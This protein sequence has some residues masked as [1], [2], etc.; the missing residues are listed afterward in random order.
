MA[1]PDLTER[2]RRYWDKHAGS[3]DRE[4]A[5]FE[6]VLFGDGRAWACGQ[7]HGRVLEIAVG[8]GRNLAFY[9]DT[10]TLTGIDVSPE[11]LGIA[12]RRAD[13]LARPVD[14]QV[15][16]AKALVFPD[17]S[18]D[19]VVCTLSL[20][21]IPDVDRAVAEMKRVLRP[22]GRLLL[23][24]HVAGASWEVRAVQRLLEMV[25]VRVGGEHLLRRPL[26]QVEAAGFQIER[27]ERSKRG[28]VERLVA[29]KPPPVRADPV[30]AASELDADI[31]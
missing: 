9:P 31:G 29:R 8:T 25:T 7:A 23:L 21:G 2:Q 27:R 26:G 24:D 13:E 10:V 6:R 3:Y 22:G 17:D 18:F 1:D 12:R 28:I 5:F 4:M 14:L 30:D 20:C 16:D 15:G 19:T 11:M